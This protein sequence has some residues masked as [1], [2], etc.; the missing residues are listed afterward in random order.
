MTFKL[1][2]RR[3]S[4]R[5]MSLFKFSSAARRT[6]LNVSQKTGEPISAPECRRGQRRLHPLCKSAQT[7]LDL[8]ANRKTGTDYRLQTT[9]PAISTHPSCGQCWARI[10]RTLAS[11]PRNACLLHAAYPSSWLHWFR[12]KTCQMC[13]V[14]AAIELVMEVHL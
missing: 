13:P 5:T 8:I 10:V 4:P 12:R 6:M 9:V 1:G 7:V 14:C 3:N 11:C 2:S